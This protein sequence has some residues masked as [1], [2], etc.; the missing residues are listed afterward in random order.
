MNNDQ[1]EQRRD[2][3]DE[4]IT[5]AGP[6]TMVNQAEDIIKKAA[7]IRNNLTNYGETATIGEGG[8]ANDQKAVH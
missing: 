1:T 8:T 2:D 4:V 5:R 6:Y 7:E 3:Q